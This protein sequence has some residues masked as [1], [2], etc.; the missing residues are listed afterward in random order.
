M[1]IIIK[2]AQF[3]NEA[4]KGQIR[5]YTGRPYIT[6]PLRVAGRAALLEKAT[7]E[8]VAAAWL[9]DTVEDCKITLDQIEELFGETVRQYIWELTNPSK[10][11]TL[12]RAD[13]KEMDRRHL[14]VV[15]D[16]AKCIKLLD[17][18]DNLGEAANAPS[19]WLELYLKESDLLRQEIGGVCKELDDELKYWLNTYGRQFGLEF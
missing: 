18:I 14:R 13:R 11:S 10:G 19:D 15:S 12:P 5:K 7:E 2:A 17:R 1:S 6:H 8:K 3:A 4:H 16:E 9:H